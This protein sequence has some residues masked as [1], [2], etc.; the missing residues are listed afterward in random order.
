M[1]KSRVNQNEFSVRKHRILISGHRLQVTH[2]ARKLVYPDD[3]VSS[4]KPKDGDRLPMSSG[5]RYGP[6][7][8]TRAPTPSP[9]LLTSE[10]A[11]RRQLKPSEM[12]GQGHVTGA[13]VVVRDDGEVPSIG[14]H[15][16]AYIVYNVYMMMKYSL[17]GTV[18]K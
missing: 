7:P 4:V 13:K 9:R 8:V 3:T 6:A 11:S 2:V 16:R 15:Y 12:R 10:F 18:T 1:Y 5:R 14:K 17:L